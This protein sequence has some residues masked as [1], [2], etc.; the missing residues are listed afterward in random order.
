MNL[1]STSVP[2]HLNII[3]LSQILW[4]RMKRVLYLN[5]HG[6]IIYLI[7]TRW[8]TIYANDKL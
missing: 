6:H 3:S 5:F 4:L 7:W 1:E 8:N 2:H